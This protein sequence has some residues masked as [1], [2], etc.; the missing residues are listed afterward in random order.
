M[1]FLIVGTVAF[2]TLVICEL[3]KAQMSISPIIIR[4]TAY[5]GGLARFHVTISNTGK[6]PLSCEMGTSAMKVETG[7]FPVE[8]KEAPR[9]CKKWVTLTPRKFTLN[10]REGKRVLCDLRVPRDA[11]GGYYAIVYCQG[12]PIGTE[13]EVKGEPGVKA[14][15]RFSYRMIAA[16][17]LTIPGRDVK[18]AIE[19]GQPFIQKREGT[20]GYI[21]KV[22]VRNRGN[23]HARLEG[24]I[25]LKSCSGQLIERILL[26][27][28]RGFMIPQHE[29]LFTAKAGINL[30]DGTYITEV[31]L[32]IEGS[33]RHMRSIFPFYIKEGRPTVGEPTD[34]LLAQLKKKSAGFVISCPKID[35]QMPPGGRR[36]KAVEVRN[37]TDESL[38]LNCKVREWY[39]SPEGED[40][41]V[42]EVPPHGRSAAG[43]LLISGKDFKILARSKKR[44][45]VTIALPR[46]ASGEYYAVIVFDRP[47]TELENSPEAL[48]RRSLLVQVYSTK[49]LQQKLKLQ[50]FT[51]MCKPTGALEFKISCRNT[52]QVGITPEIGI[53]IKDSNGKEVDKIQPKI[54]NVFIQA[55]TER[56]IQFEWRQVLDPG[57]YN[58]E[59]ALRFSS[60]QPP[61]AQRAEF[62]VPEPPTS[63]K[64]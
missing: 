19:A 23:I 40:L 9:S 21:V 28:G 41:I 51:A 30:A 59:L 22:P 39:R 4:K 49:K 50:D 58:A 11:K 55:G 27:A 25:E 17:L 24:V 5:P 45:P 14:G 63:E 36:T 29:R 37:L 61:I 7:G 16:F 33:S 56:L 48:L 2:L 1:L 57:H 35:F 62:Y 12:T 42:R 38:R 3:A 60:D 15:I 34:E 18:A 6:F 64:D 46:D 10:P 26:T 13:K 20:Q 54:H 53:S 43:M 31:N 8:V 44:V 52:G 47:E 32:R